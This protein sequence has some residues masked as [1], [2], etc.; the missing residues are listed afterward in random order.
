MANVV[1]VVIRAKD[2][3]SGQIRQ[4]NTSVGKT[5][6]VAQ[7]AAVGVGAMGT[8]VSGLSRAISIV[9]PRLGAFLGTFGS[10][11]VGAKG[12]AASMGGVSAAAGAA[13]GAVA[14][15]TA[16]NTAAVASTAN[17]TR[18]LGLLSGGFIALAATAASLGLVFVKSV[19]A[20]AS[21]QTEMTL[22]AT[23][24]DTADAGLL[25]DQGLGGS[26][27]FEAYGKEYLMVVRMR[28]ETKP[29]LHNNG[30]FLLEFDDLGAGMIKRDA[31]G[32]P[33]VHPMH[34]A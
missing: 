26:S 33:L 18:G 12:A 24:V 7:K 23:L 20:A 4:L 8:Q 31:S 15:S 6:P 13:G 27:M 11:T 28:S 19:G 30:T 10:L 25:G 17:L 32:K 3:A 9:S 2:L 1:E 14:G 21:F 22:V 16:A 34:P 5:G 29:E